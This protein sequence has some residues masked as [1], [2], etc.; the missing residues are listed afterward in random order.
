MSQITIHS[1]NSANW[2]E[3][4]P[5]LK[6]ICEQS[7]DDTSPAAVNYHWRDW[8]NTPASLMYVLVREKR[9]DSGFL[10]LLYVDGE[11]VAVNGCYTADWSDR[12]LVVGSRVY[13]RPSS[14][15]FS[16]GGIGNRWYHGRYLFPR[17]WQFAKDPDKGY[18]AVVMTFNDH[19]ARLPDFIE[20]AAG[21][22]NPIYERVP[23]FY[24]H[25]R[26]LPGVYWVKFTEQTVA[27]RLIGD[28]TWAEF[29]SGLAPPRA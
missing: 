9:Y 26:V 3:F 13:T 4:E 8:E 7:E 6:R 28:T 1:I 12:V 17:Q 23:D 20:S 16:C 10:D 11:P 24:R 14:R 27:A 18:R 19:N 22:A 15:C 5:D 2:Q 29:D 25:F 21:A